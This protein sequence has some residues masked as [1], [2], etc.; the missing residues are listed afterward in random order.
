MLPHS[1]D[2]DLR[3]YVGGQ[4]SAAGSFVVQTHLD[5]CKE[6]Q[7]RLADIAIQTRW[8]GPERRAEP[9]IPVNFEGRLKLL[10][11]VTSIGPPH[12]VTVVEISRNGLKVVTPRYL[13]PRTLVQIRFSGRAVLGEVRYCLKTESGFQ[14]GLKLMEDFPKA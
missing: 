3:L 7:L 6:C 9:R 8:K 5:G 11:P 10:D 12:P 14:A 2:D 4:L 13:I 1:S